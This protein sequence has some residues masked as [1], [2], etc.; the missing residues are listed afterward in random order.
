MSFI[1]QNMS[2]WHSEAIETCSCR[3]KVYE[4]TYTAKNEP[5][6]VGGDYMLVMEILVVS[7]LITQ[8][9]IVFVVDDDN[10]DDDDVAPFLL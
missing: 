8:R 5:N 4:A 6:S 1:C 3:Y 9:D 2:W 7:P 10:D